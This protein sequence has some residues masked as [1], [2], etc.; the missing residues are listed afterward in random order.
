ML[1]SGLEEGYG[2]DV[3][4][5]RAVKK[6]AAAYDGG[7]PELVDLPRFRRPCDTGKVDTVRALMEGESLAGMEERRNRAAE[8]PTAAPR[9]PELLCDSLRWDDCAWII[10]LV[11]R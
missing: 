5:L 2:K 8:T 9:C 11:D 6:W 10:S 4:S 7:C 3:I 1:L